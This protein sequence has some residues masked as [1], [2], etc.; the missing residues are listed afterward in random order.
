MAS[1]SALSDA[2]L[3]AEV[4]RLNAELSRLNHA[5]PSAANKS[6]SAAIKNEALAADA[7][8]RKRAQAMQGFGAT[9]TAVASGTAAEIGKAAKWG[10]FG[11]ATVAVLVT[12]F[13]VWRATK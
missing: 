5:T 11:V 13:F 1:Y 10:G 4:T 7:E 6:M 8:L 3:K 9:I 2:A 12:G